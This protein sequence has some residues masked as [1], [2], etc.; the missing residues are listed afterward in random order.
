MVMSGD[1]TKVLLVLSADVLDRARVLAGKATA[2]L[3]LSVSLQIVLRSLIEAGLKRDNVPA[4]LDSIERQAR[5]MRQSRSVARR[6]ARA[7]EK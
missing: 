5:A 2:T 6:H 3:K 1:K 7:A 4:L